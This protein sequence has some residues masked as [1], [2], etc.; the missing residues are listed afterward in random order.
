M[1]EKKI[2]VAVENGTAEE[3]KEL[4][5]QSG[6]TNSALVK[7]GLTL[8]RDKLRGV[9]LLDEKEGKDAE[10]TSESDS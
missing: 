3:L 2:L 6:M 10:T 7:R 9:G 8:L 5:E 1:A 4:R